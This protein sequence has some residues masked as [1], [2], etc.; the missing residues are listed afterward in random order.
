MFVEA[1][2]PSV[3]GLGEE[4]HKGSATP[5]IAIGQIPESELPPSDANQPLPPNDPLGDVDPRKARD[6]TLAGA[7]NNLWKT[8]LQGAKIYKALDGWKTAG[9][10]LGPHVSKILAWLH[11]FLAVGGGSPPSPPP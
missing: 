7:V 8:F 1:A 2:F 5:A 9:E 10:A 4:A 3:V 6:F 11:S